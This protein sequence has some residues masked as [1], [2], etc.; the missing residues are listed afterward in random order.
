MLRMLCSIEEFG[1][2][3]LKVIN[4][5]TSGSVVCIYGSPSPHSLFVSQLPSKE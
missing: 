1:G 2:G 4:E 3:D 5:P